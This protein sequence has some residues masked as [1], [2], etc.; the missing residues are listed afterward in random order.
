VEQH[1]RN[2]KS[3]I[4][5]IIVK[6]KSKFQIH[7]VRVQRG[8]NCGSDHYEVRAKVYLPIRRRTSNTDK[9]EENYV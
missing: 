9:H 6:Q 8:I 4:D 3:I 1:T 7:D 2:L 5:C